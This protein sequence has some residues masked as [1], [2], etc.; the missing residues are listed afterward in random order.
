MKRY[1]QTLDIPNDKELIK[2]YIE[3]HT[4]VWPEIIVGQRAVGIVSMEIY[5]HG[6][7]AFMIMDTVDEFDWDRDM[8]R[9]AT[10]PRQ[11]EWEAHVSHFQNCAIDVKAS[12]KWQR[13]MKIF[14]SKE[15]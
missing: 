8:A 2:K 4:E 3:V 6:H 5:A 12:D 7:T 1:C 13:C 11:A 15:R 9:L 14:D 10:M